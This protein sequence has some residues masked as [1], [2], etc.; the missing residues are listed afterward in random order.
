MTSFNPTTQ[1]YECPWP[2]PNC[3]LRWKKIISRSST[4]FNY[5]V[6]IWHRLVVFSFSFSSRQMSILSFVKIVFDD[7]SKAGLWK[8]LRLPSC[9]HGFESQAHHLHFYSRILCYICHCI[10]ERTKIS[11]KRPYLAHT[12]KPKLDWLVQMLQLI[13]AW[14]N[15]TNET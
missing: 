10:G 8:Y 5:Y 15:K 11:I 12:L 3:F 6:R 14:S 9:G 4:G 2:G 13:K 1:I 7:I